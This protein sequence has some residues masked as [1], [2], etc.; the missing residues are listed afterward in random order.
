MRFVSAVV[1]LSA[2]CLSISSATPERYELRNLLS[3]FSNEE[4]LASEDTRA[5]QEFKIG[6]LSPQVRMP[7]SMQMKRS[8]LKPG[9]GDVCHEKKIVLAQLYQ[10]VEE[11]IQAFEKC[12]LTQLQEE[13][14]K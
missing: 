14:K 9:S 11:E 7:L 4:P 3:K 1:L 8:G 10:I 13:G 6:Q 12:I 2:I 5:R